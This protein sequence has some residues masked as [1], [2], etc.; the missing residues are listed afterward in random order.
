MTSWA[1][2]IQVY[3]LG[4]HPSMDVYCSTYWD[5][6]HFVTSCLDGMGMK[7]EIFRRGED[8]SAKMESMSEYWEWVKQLKELVE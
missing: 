2:R 4:M 6:E 5:V 3:R 7:W 1:F 8:C